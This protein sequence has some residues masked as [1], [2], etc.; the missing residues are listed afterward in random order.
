MYLAFQ[1]DKYSLEEAAAKLNNIVPKL[2]SVHGTEIAGPIVHEAKV[3]M[4]KEYIDFVFDE[5]NKSKQ[6]PPKKLVAKKPKKVVKPFKPFKS[7]NN[8][9]EQQALSR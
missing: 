4:L 8:V 3:Q 7:N 6:P 9:A 2:E 5:L 1:F